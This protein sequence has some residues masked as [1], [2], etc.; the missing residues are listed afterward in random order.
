MGLDNPLHIAFLLIVLLLVF[1]AKR[2]PEVGRSLGSGL[3]GFKESL[4][5]DTV[6]Q[7]VPARPQLAAAEATQALGQ[8]APPAQAASRAATA[9]AADVTPLPQVS[10]PMPPAA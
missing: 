6:H 4:S 10:D 1:G 8:A 2:L 7:P 3:R 9:P 5:A